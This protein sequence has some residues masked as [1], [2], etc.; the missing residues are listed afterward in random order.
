MLQRHSFSTRSKKAAMTLSLSL[1]CSEIIQKCR[2]KSM[3]VREKNLKDNE[4]EILSLPDLWI[5]RF[6]RHFCR[7]FMVIRI[8]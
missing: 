5:D 1:I 7:R 6:L 4:S 3:I 8:S 2:N